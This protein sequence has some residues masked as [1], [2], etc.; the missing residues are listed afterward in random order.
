MAEDEIRAYLT[1]L[2][3]GRHVSASTR[4]VSLA[5]L[6]FLYRDVLK[7]QLDRIDDVQ[8]ARRPTRLPVVFSRKKSPRYSID[9]RV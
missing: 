8:R 3:V 5:S 9:Y 2:A 6:L 7:L 4:N 1:H